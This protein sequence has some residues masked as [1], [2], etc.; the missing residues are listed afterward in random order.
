MPASSV[1]TLSIAA[2]TVVPPIPSSMSRTKSSMS[3]SG[4]LDRPART[5]ELE[6]ERQCAPDVVAGRRDQVDGDLAGDRRDEPDVAPEAR[7]REVD[8]R[9]DAEVVEPSAGRATARR[10][11]SPSSHSDVAT[12][13]SSSRS[14]TKTC[15]CIRV[16]P[17]VVRIAGAEECLDRC[18]G[19]ASPRPDRRRSLAGRA[20][21]LEQAPGVGGPRG[22][23]ASSAPS[24][25]G[26]DGPSRCPRPAVPSEGA[27]RDRACGTASGRRRGRG[28][29]SSSRSSSTVTIISRAWNCGSA[30]MSAMLLIRLTGIRRSR[31][32]ATTSSAVRDARPRPDHLVEFVGTPDAAPG[33]STGRGRPR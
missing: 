1:T 14:R 23:A 29:A 5:V 32:R 20:D 9:P 25:R 31:R 30:T 21:T 3:G 22:G 24:R 6:V 12:F 18:H 15:S 7:D 17:S 28:A 8:D 4:P 11:A 19:S 33:W 10:I 2:R 26:A 27:A 13:R 16:G